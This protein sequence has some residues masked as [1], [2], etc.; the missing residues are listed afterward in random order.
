MAASNS[1]IFGPNGLKQELL[2]FIDAAQVVKPGKSDKNDNDP[3]GIEVLKEFEHRDGPN[4][5]VNGSADEEAI[6]GLPAPEEDTNLNLKLESFLS[7]S[8]DNSNGG[9]DASALLEVQINEQPESNGAAPTPRPPPPLKYQGGRQGLPAPSQ[10]RV[11]SDEVRYTCSACPFT[12]NTIDNIASHLFTHTEPTCFSCP[13]CGYTTKSINGFKKHMAEHTGELLYHCM[14]C[15]YVSNDPDYF[16]LH[17]N[18]HPGKDKFL[19]C[20]TCHC[21][22]QAR[23]YKSHM[24]IHTDNQP[25]VCTECGF[26]CTNMNILMTHKLMHAVDSPFSN[27]SFRYNFGGMN[28]FNGSLNSQMNP[29]LPSYDQ[30][31]QQSWQRP[32]VKTK[33]PKGRMTAYSFYVQL[34]RKK[35]PPDL[36]VNWV[37]FSRQCSDR[38]KSMSEEDKKNFHE[39]AEADKERYQNEMAN[40]NP[41][42]G[43]LHTQGKGKHGYFFKKPKD[44]NRPKRAQ[45]AFF[46]F[47]NDERQKV[48]DL[49]PDLSV[50]DVAKELG[51]K[52]KEMTSEE[53]TSFEKMAEEDRL[54]YYKAMDVYKTGEPSIKKLKTNGESTGSARS[55]PEPE[56]DDDDIQFL[57]ASDP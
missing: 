2:D 7:D 4:D 15:E 40:W 23:D 53:K 8:D 29:S 21:K 46:Y 49:N 19:N 44:P 42:P 6:L 30:S 37:E 22:L 14:F 55:T 34:E 50:G 52:W 16:D 43:V 47:A 36:N 45:S 27:N 35:L 39:K 10:I 24:L 3:I 38:W 54:R 41:G 9:I 18:F 12:D 31:L 1:T 32:P 26:S 11:S 48:R 25:L 57:F 33:K 13:A 56:E 17:M 51:R 5:A 20:K 28:M